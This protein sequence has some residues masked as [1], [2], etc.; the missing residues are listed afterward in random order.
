MRKPIR[1]G[2]AFRA[3]CRHH[4]IDYRTIA[5]ALDVKLGSASN[6]LAARQW[7]NGIPAAR[8]DAVDALIERHNG[9]ELDQDLERLLFG[10]PGAADTVELNVPEPAPEEMVGDTPVSVA[11]IRKTGGGV[12]SKRLSRAGKGKLGKDSSQCWLSDGTIES[13]SVSMEQLATELLPSLER[14]SALVLTN[15]P[16]ESGT[17]V[18]STA[19]AEEGMVTRTRRDMRWVS[20]FP[21]VLLI[22]GDPSAEYQAESVEQFIEDC[23]RIIPQLPDC[24]RV[25]SHSTSSWV[26]TKDGEVLSG[27]GG[28]HVYL[29]AK[30][31]APLL[32]NNQKALRDRVL[33]RGWLAGLGFIFVDRAGKQ[34]PRTIIDTSVWQPERIAFEAPPELEDG[35]VQHRPPPVWRDGVYLDL[36]ELLEPLSWEEQQEYQ[37][38]VAEAKA[39]TKATADET[40]AAYLETESKKL[41]DRTGCSTKVAYRKVEARTD[42]GVLDA[43]EVLYLNEWAGD[44]GDAP[45]GPPYAVGVDVVLRDPDPFNWAYCADPVEPDYGGTPGSVVATKARIHVDRQGDVRVYSWAHG[46]RQFLCQHAPETLREHLSR[47]AERDLDDFRAEYP[48]IVARARLDDADIDQMVE[49]LKGRAEL[50][51]VTKPTIRRALK[52]AM[53]GVNPWLRGG[54]ADLGIPDLGAAT[55]AP[56][57]PWPDG[58]D[59]SEGGLYDAREVPPR[60]VC[61]P[62]EPLALARDDRSRGW[63]PL[64]R[65]QDQDGAIHEEVIPRASMVGDST[66]ALRLLAAGGLRMAGGSAAA[67]ALREALSGVQIDRRA[68]TCDTPGW[69]GAAYLWGPHI[70]GATDGSEILLWSGSAGTHHAYAAGTLEEWQH[71]V[72]RLAGGNSRL[73]LAIGIALAGPLLRWHPQGKGGVHLYDTSSSGKSS[74][75]EAAGSVMGGLV[76]PSPN[77]QGWLSGWNSTAVGLEGAALRHHHATLILDE[78]GAFSGTPQQAASIIYDLSNG[79]TKGRGS[80]DGTDRARKSF[81]LLVLSTGEVT[82]ADMLAQDS[83]GAAAPAGG[84]QVRLL[85]LPAVPS[86]R[87]SPAAQVHGVFE[88]LHEFSGGAALADHLRAASRR[89]YGTALPAFV[90]V[91][92]ALPETEIAGCIRDSVAQLHGVVRAEFQIE[93]VP[94]QLGRMLD[95][96]GL[97]AAAGTLAERARIVLWDEGEAL[98]AMTQIVLEWL[99][100]RGSLEAGEQLTAIQFVRRVLFSQRDRFVRVITVTVSDGS[101]RHGLPSNRPTRDILGYRFEGDYLVPAEV[102]ESELVP[103][104]MSPRTTRQQLAAA[105]MLVT[106]EASDGV[107]STVRVRL[108]DEDGEMHRVR[109]VRIKGALLG[110]A[111][112]GDTSEPGID[113]AKGIDSETA[114]RMRSVEEDFGDLGFA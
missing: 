56:T 65:W 9:V 8:H 111:D 44:A 52:D 33:A 55:D 36:D 6:I 38:L 4:E 92:V 61:D 34:H 46:G 97:I 70:I 29:V 24:A 86:L 16:F 1:T 78:M 74:A 80:V 18:G 14:D 7:K 54:G 110:D 91:L 71:E 3:F 113:D 40:Q 66:E 27:A 87:R 100:E 73:V 103:R 98:R 22:D 58:F 81:D 112:D 42:R 25:E 48:G 72:A 35:L 101:T 76:H 63:G 102:F 96:L 15:R 47:L 88:N 12:V 85:A 82:L 69:H 108:P 45:E 11:V 62:I 75:S 26:S 21:A 2:D 30:D 31:P 32:P 77:R 23:A 49:W 84:Q 83:R 94:A 107:R 43:S 106:E 59:M 17:V 57:S 104:G 64:L 60:W 19:K 39:A 90:R 95:R 41:A 89:L 93:Q 37:R 50:T 13:N 51:G 53:E 67:G 68:L 79:L 105:G 10:D 99:D 109:V 5:E 20:G 114:D 28:Y